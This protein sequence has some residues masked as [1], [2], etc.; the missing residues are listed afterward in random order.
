M[1]MRELRI[2]SPIRLIFIGALRVKSVNMKAMGRIPS[3]DRLD[4]IRKSKNFKDGAFQNLSETKMLLEGVNYGKMLI[5]Y[6]KKPGNT[7]PPAP[8]PTVKTN[9]SALPDNKIV[10]VWFGHSSYLLRVNGFN[11]LVDPVFS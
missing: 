2:A 7:Q 6:Y 11:I 10:F 1:E 3:G 9:L 5:E 8:M 4:R